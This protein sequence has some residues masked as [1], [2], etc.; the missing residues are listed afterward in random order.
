MRKFPCGQYGKQ[1]LEFHPAPFRAPLRAFASL[2]FPWRGSEVLVCNI[3]DRGWCI[4]SGRVEPNESS[5][6]AAV[7]EA[8]EEAGADLK[9]MHYIGCY[10][11]TQRD[12]VRWVDV[13]TANVEG[14]TDLDPQFESIG[15]KF[16]TM[17]ELPDIY[18]LWNPL[19]EAVFLQSKCVLDRHEST[20]GNYRCGEK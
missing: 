1:R 10:R 13:Y 3:E 15:R 18:H 11:V 6:D 8:K 19:T 9:E 4:P 12:E 17:E 14:L 7:R 16:V 5:F 2:V 20:K